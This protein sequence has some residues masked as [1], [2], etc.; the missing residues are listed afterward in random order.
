MKPFSVKDYTKDPSRKVVTR[1]GK[2]ARV[3]CTDLKHKYPVIAALDYGY[4]EE[5]IFFYD[6]CGRLGG[7]TDSSCDLFFEEKNTKKKGWIN[8]YKSNYR[9]DEYFTSSIYWDKDDAL[10]HATNSKIQSTVLTT[11]V[12]WEE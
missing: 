12:E 4:D 1:D 2:P 5:R 9:E 11:C 3:I 10:A 8:I 7:V 6:E